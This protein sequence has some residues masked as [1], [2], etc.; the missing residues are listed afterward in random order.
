MLRYACIGHR[1]KQIYA[2]GQGVNQGRI[3]GGWVSTYEQ[4]AEKTAQLAHPTLTQGPALGL[5][6]WCP[7]GSPTPSVL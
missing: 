3:L 1:T 6:S 4:L 5:P 2:R 7:A